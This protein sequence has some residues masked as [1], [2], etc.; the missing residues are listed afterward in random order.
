MKKFQHI[1]VEVEGDRY[2]VGGHYHSYHNGRQ[3][4]PDEPE[5]FEIL[6]VR[7]EGSDVDVYSEIDDSLFAEL[8][9]AALAEVLERIAEERECAADM[10]RDEIRDRYT[11]EAAEDRAMERDAF[12]SVREYNEGRG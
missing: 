6:E 12:E 9:D 10:R 8:S 4:E 7:R 2:E 5:C 11:D 1:W 3:V